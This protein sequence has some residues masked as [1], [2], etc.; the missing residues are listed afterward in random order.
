MG[1]ASKVLQLGSRSLKDPVIRLLE[2]FVRVLQRSS[3][4]LDLIFEQ[5]NI[6]GRLNGCSHDHLLAP[7]HAAVVNEKDGRSKPEN[8][9]GHNGKVSG[10]VRSKL[11]LRVVAGVYAQH[12]GALLSAQGQPSVRVI[13]SVKIKKLHQV[14]APRPRYVACGP[15]RR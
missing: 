7:L 11:G 14:C 1:H 13:M 2:S 15:S 4:F 8:K 6:G 12:I 10:I 5:R 9:N 3:P